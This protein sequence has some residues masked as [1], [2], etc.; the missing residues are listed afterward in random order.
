MQIRNGAQTSIASPA[1]NVYMTR[2]S[3][4][5]DGR[6]D[7]ALKPS[8]TRTASVAVVE[9]VTSVFAL[10]PGGGGE[11][12]TGACPKATTHTTSVRHTTRIVFIPPAWNLLSAPQRC[13]MKG[14]L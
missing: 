13:V 5:G 4:P 7:S 1:P 2:P 11:T 3:G 6:F 12:A 8:E 14:L 9:S 10:Y